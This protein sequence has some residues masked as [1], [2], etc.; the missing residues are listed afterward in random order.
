[1]KRKHLNLALL[2]VTALLI[3]AVVLSQEEEAPPPPLTSLDS[4]AITHIEVRHPD[5]PEIKLDMTDKG[6]MI[7]EPVKI[8]ADTLQVDALTALAYRETSLNYPAAEVDLARLGLSPPQ[9]TIQ[10][11]D[12]ELHFGNKEP[13]QDR[14]YV[15]VGDKVFLAS[16]PPSTALDADYSDLVHAKL[17]PE[18]TPAISLLETP[19]LKLEQ[20][21]ETSW[22]V[23]PASADHGPDARA[24]LLAHWENARSLWRT[25]FDPATDKPIEGDTI[26]VRFGGKDQPIIEYQ[27]I[28]RDQQLL[29]LR[30]DLDVV[31]TLPPKY[32]IDLFE[33]QKPPQDPKVGEGSVKAP[34]EAEPATED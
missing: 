25:R 4:E 14:R 29:L 18:G 10:L 24:K 15:Q 28:K 1:M 13:V 30:K 20:V 33:L 22:K 7:T 26:R 11:D 19:K 32:G 31:Y 12:T 5:R 21:D 6:W 27:V 34:A 9:W 3:L 16:D 17:M 23:T 2:L 8:A